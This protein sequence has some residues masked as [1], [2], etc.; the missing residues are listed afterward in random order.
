MFVRELAIYVEHLR[1][2]F[3]KYSLELSTR[4]P[5][6]FR[7]FKE[8]LLSGI[9]YYRSRT[10]HFIDEKRNRFLDDLQSLREAL[11]HMTVVKPLTSE[12]MGVREPEP[13][14]ALWQSERTVART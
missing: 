4:A 1:E 13:S 12:A 10:E 6:Y 5:K 3:E 11:E 8:N 7:E 14:C 2:E 9:E